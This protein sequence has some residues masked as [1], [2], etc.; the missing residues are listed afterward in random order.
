MFH[1]E[2]SSMDKCCFPGYKRCSACCELIRD[3]ECEEHLSMC[4]PRT[5]TTVA[6]QRR[7]EKKCLIC[8]QIFDEKDYFAHIQC[9][10]GQRQR[11]T[12]TTKTCLIW[13]K[14]INANK[15]IDHIEQCS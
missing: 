3:E 15:Y 10:D 2:R 11:R 1:C 9:C 12:T 4:Q 6:V 7:K 8:E 5:T 13:L 14:S